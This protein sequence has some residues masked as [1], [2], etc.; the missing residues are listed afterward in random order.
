MRQKNDDKNVRREQKKG[1]R[2][3]TQRLRKKIIRDKGQENRETKKMRTK[4]KTVL[5]RR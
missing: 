3:P 2:T 4:I 1:G 5:K